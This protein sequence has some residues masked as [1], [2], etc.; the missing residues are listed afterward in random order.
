MRDM[1]RALPIR[2]FILIQQICRDLRIAEPQAF[3][4]TERSFIL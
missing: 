4:A 2:L 1:L 3:N